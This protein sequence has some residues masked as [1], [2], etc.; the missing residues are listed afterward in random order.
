MVEYSKINVK[1]TDTQLK[2]LKTAVKNKT[3][4]NLRMSLK[5]LDGNDLPHELLLTTRQ[6]TRLRNAF[7]NNMSND[8]KLS[9]AQISIIISIWSVFMIIVE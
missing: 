3:G 2:K 8:L 9:K 4:T 6:K 7:N 1:L 5:M